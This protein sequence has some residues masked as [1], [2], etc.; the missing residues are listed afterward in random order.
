MKNMKK[1]VWRNEK[2]GKICPVCGKMTT[3]VVYNWETRPSCTARIVCGRYDHRIELFADA[4]TEN[5][6]VNKVMKNWDK[7]F[8]KEEHERNQNNPA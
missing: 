3:L 7:A 4:K 6:A 2:N 5:A 1:T 8:G